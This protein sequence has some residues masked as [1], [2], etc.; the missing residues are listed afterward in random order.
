MADETLDPIASANPAQDTMTCRQLLESV[1]EQLRFDCARGPD[2]VNALARL[3]V[4]MEASFIARLF[5]EFVECF[6]EH[7]VAEH[8]FLHTA[9]HGPD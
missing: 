2:L 7:E 8:H 5:D 3:S 9:F 6:M 4:N 1:F